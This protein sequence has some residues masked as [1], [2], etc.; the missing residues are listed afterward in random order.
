MHYYVVL[1]MCLYMVYI[2]VLGNVGG[3][4]R[5]TLGNCFQGW[6][7]GHWACLTEPSCWPYCYNVRA[8]WGFP[9][10]DPQ[11]TLGKRI[12]TTETT[13]LSLTSPSAQVDG[14]EEG[15]PRPQAY[16]PGYSTQM[17]SATSWVSC[18]GVTRTVWPFL[19]AP[20]THLQN[21]FHP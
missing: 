17:C 14:P 6:N 4:Q 21:L 8:S 18:L 12:M 3:G 10:Q 19:L 5:S 20:E 15:L 9:T 2:C 13:G 7:S 16:T 11:F 1:C